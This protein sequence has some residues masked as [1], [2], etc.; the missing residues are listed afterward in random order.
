M[1]NIVQVSDATVEA[2]VYQSDRPVLVDFWAAWCGPCKAVEP[3]LEVLA[4]EFED[5]LKVVKVNVDDNPGF[6]AKMGI[7]SIPTLS[8]FRDGQLSATKTGA[9]S[10]SELRTFLSANL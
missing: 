10:L 7:R 1:T 3:V 4:D 9:G 2:E 5:E 6:A 8:L